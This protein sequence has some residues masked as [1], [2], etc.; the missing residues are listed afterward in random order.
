MSGLPRAARAAFPGRPRR[1]PVLVRAAPVRA[2]SSVGQSTRLISVGSEVQVLPGPCRPV[3]PLAGRG[4][5]SAGRAPALQ[6]GGRRF[7]SDRLHPLRNPRRPLRP[8]LAVRRGGPAGSFTGES[9]LC[10]Q[11]ARALPLAA[12]AAEVS[13]GRPARLCACACVCV[14]VCSFVCPSARERACFARARC[15]AAARGPPGRRAGPF[16]ARQGRSVDAL[17]LRGDEGRGTLRKAAGRCER[18]L[19]RGC[20]NGETHPA[21]GIPGRIHGPGRRTRGTETS[22]YPEEKTSTE[23]PGVVASETGP[24]QWPLREK[25]KDLERSAA[26]GDSPVGVAFARVLE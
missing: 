23:I 10:V 7:E 5:S 8:T 2:S 9:G 4:R 18:S 3:G 20:P 25:P 16:G 11:C 19:I 21:R 12:A 17:A 22:Q 14:F 26:A 13:A 6:A 24:G 15:S 1:R